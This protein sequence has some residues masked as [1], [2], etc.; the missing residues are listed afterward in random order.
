M[1]LRDHSSF[2]SKLRMCKSNTALQEESMSELPAYGTFFRKIYKAVPEF[3]TPFISLSFSFVLVSAAFLVS[4]RI[5]A[6][7]VLETVFGWPVDDVV[8]D[9]AA[10]TIPP[11]VHSSLL[12]PGLIVALLARKYSPTEHMSKASAAWQD[13]VNGLL[14]FCTG[15]MLNDSLFLVYRAQQ[16]SGSIFPQLGF[17]DILF[18]G[19]HAM[20]SIYMTQARIYQAGHMSAMMCM[21]VGELSNPFHNTYWFLEIASGLDCCDGPKLQQARTI[22]PTL[23]AAV[24]VFLRV[25]VSPPILIYTTYDLLMNKQGKENLPLGVRLFWVFMIWA[26]MVGSIPELMTC[27]GLLESFWNGEEQEL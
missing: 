4:V 7:K 15:Y 5:L 21:L 2:I 20:T 18:L 26:V 19:H 22:V 17:E 12:C 25:V 10:S 16:L 14:Q 8:T 27:K 13:L 23:F 1:S 24:Y 11:I 6:N 3:K 9:R